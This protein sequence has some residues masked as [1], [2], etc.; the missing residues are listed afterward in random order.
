MLAFDFSSDM[1]LDLQTIESAYSLV[2]GYSSVQSAK[3]AV[4]SPLLTCLQHA[5]SLYHGPFLEGFSINEA[6]NFDDWIGLKR[7]VW[8][9]RESLIFDRLS[10]L[11][12]EAGELLSAIEIVTRWIA[13]DPLYESAQRRL[14]A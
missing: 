7:E 6:P 8:H 14:L 4:R 1:R 9:Q 3:E 10:Q 12:L 2:R 5:A 11:Q 13:L